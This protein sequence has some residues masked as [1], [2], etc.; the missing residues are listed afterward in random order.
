[1]KRIRVL[2]PRRRGGQV[3]GI[4]KMAA[5]PEQLAVMGLTSEE[6][7]KKMIE[8]LV[9]DA[10]KANPSTTIEAARAAAIKKLEPF[11]LAINEATTSESDKNLNFSPVFLRNVQEKTKNI[12]LKTIADQ[13]NF[14][15]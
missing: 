2:K 13:V 4:A 14:S 15:S 3:S 7:V 8:L 1:M 9:R 6:N 5:P 11:Y 10:R 12:N